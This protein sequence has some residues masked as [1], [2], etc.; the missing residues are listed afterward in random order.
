MPHKWLCGF[1]SVHRVV[2]AVYFIGRV[3]SGLRG[4]VI[5]RGLYNLGLS[6]PGWSG[7]APGLVICGGYG[8]FLALV[9]LIPSRRLWNR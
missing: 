8:S 7:L 3:L 2:G 1:V 6:S 4:Y 9:W 5:G